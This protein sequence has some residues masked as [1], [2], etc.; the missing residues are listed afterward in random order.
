MDNETQKIKA[1]E[2]ELGDFVKLSDGTYQEVI[3]LMFANMGQGVAI[4]LEE[5]EN[6]IV[7]S[8]TQE[9]VIKPYK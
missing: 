5:E 1:F 3:D 7:V 8:N 6:P 9:V 2:L 4:T